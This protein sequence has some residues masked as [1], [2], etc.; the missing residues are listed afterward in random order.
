MS[1][2]DIIKDARLKTLV[3]EDGQ[4]VPLALLP[5]LAEADIN[6]FESTLPC[7]LPADMRELLAY[8]R[9]FQGVVADVVDFT[10]GE[11]FFGLETV[12]PHGIPIA[13]DG[14]GN[15]WVV[16]LEWQST[17]FGPVYFACHDAPVVLYQSETLAGFLSELF[18]LCT[19]PHESLIDD[20]H[21]DRLFEVWRK[22]P[23]VMDVTSCLESDDASLREFA[24]TLD[25][26]WQIIDLRNADAGFGFSWGRYGARTE[27]QRFGA[28]PIF[29]YRRPRRLLG[30]VFG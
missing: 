24:A 12:F 19:P 7:P 25:P 11:M 3:D 5:P 2:V 6:E 1:L 14:F 21:E 27:V 10:G 20:V 23:G 13:A 4:E 16:D 29:A 28:L 8:C 18:R 15:F 9:G 22:N 30:G 26:T 17:E